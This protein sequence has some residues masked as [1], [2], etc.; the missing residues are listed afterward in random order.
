V[1]SLGVTIAWAWW[2]PTVWSLVG[3][4]VVGSAL[5][6]VLSHALA[7]ARGA[8]FAWEPSAR[9]QLVAFG[10]WIFLSTIL[11]FLASQADRLLFG[12]L[13][14]ITMLGVY[15]IALVLATVPTQL[16]W[17]I[18]SYVVLPA[19]SRGTRSG[20]SLE[21]SYRSLQI[22]VLLAGGLPIAALLACGPELIELLYDPRYADAGWMLQLVA[23]GGWIQVLQTLNANALL[24]F[25]EPRWLA[26]G[27][28]IKLLGM[29][30]LMP[31]GYALAEVPGAILGLSLS[32]LLRWGCF[33]FL[34]QRRG[35]PGFGPDLFCSAVVLGS[36]GAGWYT[37]AELQARGVGT[38]ARL[39]ASTAVV[40]VLWLAVSLALLR[41]R[42][43]ELRALA[44]RSVLR[45][46]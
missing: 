44:Q 22:P 4:A 19:F 40:S 29:F 5:K 16:L 42:L 23:L 2:L 13:F 1:L 36:A 34:V 45:R 43:P 18:G 30:V 46:T 31:G 32:E 8:G 12:K 9:R 17:S 41:D 35:L 33:A 15:G 27:N 25:G 21:R 28:G 38:A 39:C 11:A 6:L 3:G 26:L 7:P 10:K 14:S 37:V 20:G 24:A